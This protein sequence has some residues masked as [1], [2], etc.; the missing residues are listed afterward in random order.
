MISSQ[1]NSTTTILRLVVDMFFLIISFLISLAIVSYWKS[2]DILNF[3]IGGMFIAFFSKLSVTL[4]SYNIYMK[5]N[6][7]NVIL[8]VVAIYNL[9]SFISLVIIGFEYVYEVCTINFVL[10]VLFISGVRLLT[11]FY[12][13]KAIIETDENAKTLSGVHQIGNIVSEMIH[14]SF[15]TQAPMIIGKNIDK[16]VYDKFREIAP[17]SV[18]LD[19]SSGNRLEIDLVELKNS[20]N[21]NSFDSI[22][23]Y[24][25]NFFRLE[26][27]DILDVVKDI[28]FTV[29]VI[30]ES[31]S[32]VELS[33]VKDILDYF[34]LN[35]QEEVKIRNYDT[36]LLYTGTIWK[37]LLNRLLASGIRNVTIIHSEP[38]PEL[39]GN[40]F[41]RIKGIKYIHICTED[42]LRKELKNGYPRIIYGLP[43]HDLYT[44]ENEVKKTIEK[45]VIFTKTILDWIS[46]NKTKEFIFLSSAIANNPGSVL[47]GCYRNIELMIQALHGCMNVNFQVIRMPNIIKENNKFIKD[48]SKD[49]HSRV[50]EVDPQDVFIYM[51]NEK[52]AATLILSLLGKSKSFIVYM[53]KQVYLPDL[54]SDINF[55]GIWEEKLHVAF[56]EN[57]GPLELYMDGEVDYSKYKITENPY[58]F[59]L[60]DTGVDYRVAAKL[61]TRMKNSVK[62]DTDE[63]C[64]EYLGQLQ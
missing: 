44:G 3:F 13:S 2:F 8:I 19:V 35:L 51:Y 6:K 33:T 15:T 10:D 46:E 39:L 1:A 36:L 9:I 22:V 29:D 57:V 38:M 54:L 40:K 21:E 60:P 18:I 43:I 5:R 26:L 56:H 45:N 17:D 32:L 48:V 16:E 49:F 47:G 4:M 23:I 34:P 63:A 20:I 62:N 61:V 37:E 58:S 59:E 27:L 53:G 12:S 50:F 25:K 28:P 30:D 41:S 11:K 55:R 64:K 42:K 24:A 14:L 52:E 7:V 31:F